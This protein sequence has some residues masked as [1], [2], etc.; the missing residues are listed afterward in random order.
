MSELL[1]V[2]LWGWIFFNVFIVVMIAVDLFMHRQKKPMGMRQALL[3]S[4]IWIGLALIFNWGIYYFYGR[5]AALD[6]FAGYLIEKSLSIDNLFVFILIFDYFRVPRSYH[7]KVLFWGILGAIVMRAFFIY[8]GIELVNHFHWVLY[9]FG[10]FL[11]YAAFKMAMPRSEVIDPEHNFVIRWLKKVIPVTSHFDSD[12]FFTKIDYKW[13]ATPLFIVVITLEMTDLIFALDSIPAVM[14]ITLDPFIV[15]TSN[16]FAILG[17]RA[18]YFALANLMPL[19]HY[20]K[21]GLAAILAFVGCKMLLEPFIHIP[22][23]VSLGFIVTALTISICASLLHPLPPPPK[24]G[25]WD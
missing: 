12:K 16:I 2:P 8:F 20:L 18:L 13:W 9:I 24:S 23:G 14:A 22:I 5:A 25:E 15:Y 1:Q 7:H 10:A 3:M 17:L 4:A 21:Y 6:F 11:L 19:F